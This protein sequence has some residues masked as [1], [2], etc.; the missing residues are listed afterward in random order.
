MPQKLHVYSMSNL[1]TVNFLEWS[2]L[3]TMLEELTLPLSGMLFVVLFGMLVVRLFVCKKQKRSSLTRH[4][5]KTFVLLISTHLLLYPR[6]GTREDLLSFGR[7]QGFRGML[8]FKTII[9]SRWNLLQI[10]RLVPG[11]L[12]MFMLLVPPWEN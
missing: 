4:T 6:W 1:N 10:C 9:P 3:T 7:A 5:L 12:Q 11:L 8:S 2:V